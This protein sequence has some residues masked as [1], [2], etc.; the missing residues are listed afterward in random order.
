MSLVSQYGAIR[1]VMPADGNH[2]ACPACPGVSSLEHSNGNFT[3]YRARMHSIALGAGARSGTNSERFYSFSQG[4]VHFVVFSAEAYAYS[5]GAEFIANQ[6]AFLKSDLAAV[7]RSVTPW[8]V[9]LVH[10]DWTMEAAAYADIYPILDAGKVDVL[11]CGHGESC[12]VLGACARLFIL[13]PCGELTFS[14][15]FPPTPPPHPP[16]PSLPPSALL[17]A[18]L[19]LRRGV[20]QDGQGERLRGWP[21]LH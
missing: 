11:F 19:P 16:A 15:P 7:D 21:H 9:A 5:S 1:P 4:L 6:L 17:Q 2:E 13:T 3:E 14:T 10:K 8:V 12:G 20:G 18:P